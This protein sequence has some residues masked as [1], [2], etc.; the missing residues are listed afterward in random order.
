MTVFPVAVVAVA[1]VVAVVVAFDVVV[2]SVAVRTVMVVVVVE[3]VV[4]GAVVLVT[5]SRRL[6]GSAGSCSCGL[7]FRGQTLSRRHQGSI[8]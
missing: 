6:E 5:V 4:V 7:R 2:V 3:V 8:L 1:F